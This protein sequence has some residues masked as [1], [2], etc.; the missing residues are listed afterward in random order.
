LCRLLPADC[1]ERIRPKNELVKHIVDLLLVH[2][3]RFDGGDVVEAGG[4]RK[5]HLI[6]YCRLLHLRHD[7]PEM[8]DSASTAHAAI[9]DETRRFVVPLLALAFG[10]A[11]VS[12]SLASCV[13]GVKMVSSA[14]FG[15]IAL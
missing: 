4:E 13:S 2:R 10:L 8:L 1:F 9:A 3:C 15:I 12:A 14:F 6:A 5:H 11:S 7:E